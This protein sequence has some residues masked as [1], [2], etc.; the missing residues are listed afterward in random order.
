MTTT[1]TIDGFTVKIKW[2]F[3]EILERLDHNWVVWAVLGED[4]EGNIYSGECQADPWLN[5]TDCCEVTNIEK[6]TE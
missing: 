5:N 6:I 2:D 3:E 1:E 4:N